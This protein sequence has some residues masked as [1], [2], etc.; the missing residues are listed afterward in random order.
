MTSLPGILGTLGEINPI[1]PLVNITRY[2]YLGVAQGN[3][4]AHSLLAAFF[5]ILM[6]AIAVTIFKKGIGIRTR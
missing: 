4:W 5:L 1:Y 6:F 3:I 2:A